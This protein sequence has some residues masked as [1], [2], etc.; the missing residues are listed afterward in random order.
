MQEAFIWY[1][2]IFSSYMLFTLNTINT[3]VVLRT[4]FVWLQE[5]RLADKFWRSLNYLVLSTIVLAGVMSV[6]LVLMTIFVPLEMMAL[7]LALSVA[8]VLFF[9]FSLVAKRTSQRLLLQFP[10]PEA[11]KQPIKKL[12]NR[13][14]KKLLITYT[15]MA[16]VITYTLMHFWLTNQILP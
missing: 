7:L 14:F 13:Q 6:A 9:G 4:R 8:I 16:Y 1:I 2:I 15:I 11:E 5:P 10:L 12:L 3:F